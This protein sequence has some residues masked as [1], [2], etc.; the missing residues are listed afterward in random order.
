MKRQS[1]PF[2]V[3]VKNKR[4][5]RRPSHSIWGDVDISKAMLESTREFED[6]REEN[7]T[8]ID[9]KSVSSDGSA[10]P[11][12]T[13]ERFMANELTSKPEEPNPASSG[14]TASSKEPARPRRTK[15]SSK[16]ATPENGAKPNSKRGRA[17]GRKVY[18][19]SERAQKLS[20]I[21]KS[22]GDGAT[23]KSAIKQA[24]ISEQTYYLWKKAAAPA[25]Q[26]DDLKDLLALEEENKRLKSLLAQRLRKENAELKKKLG[27]D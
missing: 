27:L 18:S 11:Q 16:A 9:T 25:P 24:G 7:H 2:A 1:R 6:V 22:T 26:S 23:L 3:E 17:A 14:E 10:E 13:P 8:I 12:P 15:S 5:S 21:Q 4:R 19:E 20:Q